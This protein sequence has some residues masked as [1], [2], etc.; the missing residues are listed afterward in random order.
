MNEASESAAAAV[1]LHAIAKGRVQG[2][3][4]RDFVCSRAVSLGLTGYVRNLPD[5]RSVEVVAEGQRERLE[6]L[7]EHL[8]EGP[9][10]ARV[11]SVDVR[12]GEASGQYARFR[13]AF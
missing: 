7:V 13:I 12:W 10:Q 2:V 9:R 3:N 5:M 6:R 1:S 8:R 4:F 11:N